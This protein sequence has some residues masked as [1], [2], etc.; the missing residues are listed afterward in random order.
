MGAQT[1]KSKEHIKNKFSS[2][3][4]RAWDWPIMSIADPKQAAQTHDAAR[5]NDAWRR[6]LNPDSAIPRCQYVC[7]GRAKVQTVR[8]V[9]A[10]RLGRLAALLRIQKRCH[11]FASLLARHH[12]DDLECHAKT[13]TVQDPFLKQP[14]IVALHQLEA[15][16]EV[17]LD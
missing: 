2:H 6:R 4:P 12:G 7:T 8:E 10:D 3:R 14:G 11:D 16:V 13:L 9:S 15:A 1:I 17:G 5:L